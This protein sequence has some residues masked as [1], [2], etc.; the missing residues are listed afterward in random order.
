[1]APVATVQAQMPNVINN[2]RLQMQID[3]EDI[4]KALAHPSGKRA[5]LCDD[6][7]KQMA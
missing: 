6:E 7:I 4:E 2:L 5:A 3:Q 1:M